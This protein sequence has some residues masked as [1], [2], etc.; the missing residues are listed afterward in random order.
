[1]TIESTSTGFQSGH[2]NIIVTIQGITPASLEM[3]DLTIE[4]ER[5]DISEHIT[6]WKG[7]LTVW[8]NP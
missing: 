2:R 8:G 6:D 7:S 3:A 5:K 4:Y 1:V